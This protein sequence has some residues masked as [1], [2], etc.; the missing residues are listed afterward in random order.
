MVPRYRKG[1]EDEGA[2]NGLSE[3]QRKDVALARE[4]PAHGGAADPGERYEDGIRPM[5]RREECPACDSCKIG[6][7]KGA[8][9]SIHGEGLQ[10]YLLKMQRLTKRW[11]AEE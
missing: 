7:M 8:Q 2:E 5:E 4:E 6:I 1:P 11:S 9:Q 10:T 3:D